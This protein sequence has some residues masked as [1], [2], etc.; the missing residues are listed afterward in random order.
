MTLR[1]R[2]QFWFASTAIAF[3]ATVQAAP[4][5][6]IDQRLEDVRV[7]GISEVPPDE[8]M[9]TGRDD[10]MLLQERKLF[11]LSASA[12]TVFTNNAYLSNQLRRSDTIFDAQVNGRL[13]TTI[14]Q[15]YDVYAQAG[16]LTSQ[17]THHQE[18]GYN[19]I[20]AS[21]GGEAPV[22]GKLRAGVQY[23]YTMAFDKDGFSEQLVTLND[24]VAYANYPISLGA[25]NALIPQVALD[26]TVAAPSDYDAWAVRGS[27]NLV[28]R[29]NPTVVGVL[30]GELG[31]KSYDSY[32]EYATGKSRDDTTLGLNASV[33]WAPIDAVQLSANVGMM[34]DD[35]T[36]KS[37]DYSAVS[38]TPNLLLKVSF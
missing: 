7:S 1:F 38:F 24:F 31:Y 22:W 23:G 6:A 30:G 8:T 13:A 10:L 4:Q 9:L 11:T 36:V 35:S 32:F 18:L 33:R 27:L 34:Y 20:S 29:F 12:D 26:R 15:K 3:A 2:K 17:Y 19:G 37:N 5:D 25:N 28:H 21:L 14:A 16:I